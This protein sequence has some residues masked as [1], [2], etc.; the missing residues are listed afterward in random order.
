[1]I[2]KNDKDWV[3]SNP[4]IFWG[5]IAPCNHLVQIYESDEVFMDS[6]EEFVCSGLNMGENVVLVATEVHLDAVRKRLELYGFN[7][8]KLD[9]EHRFIGL[10]AE[11]TLAK[12]MIDNW[13]DEILFRNT[14]SEVIEQAKQ[15]GRPI[16]VF[17]EMVAVLWAQGHCGATVRLEHLWNEFCKS[18]TFS[19]F[20]AYPRSGFTQ[21]ANTSI[22]E[23]CSTHSKILGGWEKPAM[24]VFYKHGSYTGLAQ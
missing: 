13:P 9:D 5:E 23:I 17:G 18:E 20:C 15:N 19:L 4:Q 21:D 10:N 16:R 12:F 6:L 22:M 2:G 7:L 1:M 8:H 3:Q 14:V 24:E 11:E